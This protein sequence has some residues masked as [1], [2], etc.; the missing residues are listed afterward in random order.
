MNDDHRQT[1]V[2]DSGQDTRKV[3]GMVAASAL[4]HLAFFALM[5]FMPTSFTS[6]H[7]LTPR[8]AIS[9]DLVSL[10]AGEPAPAAP[11]VDATPAPVVKQEPPPR[12]RS[13]FRRPN[14]PRCLSLPSPNPKK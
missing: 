1:M 11:P 6:S 12:R 2:L 9:V 8:G 4:C 14:R 10:P 7:R 3:F 5:V 13:P